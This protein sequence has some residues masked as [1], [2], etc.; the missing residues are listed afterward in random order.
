M[1]KLDAMEMMA[2]RMALRVELAWMKEV[3]K[4]SLAPEVKA[5]YQ[6]RHDRVEELLALFA[7][8][9]TVTIGT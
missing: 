6:N 8:G 9:H 4:G 5:D 3:V 1:R 2:I 7:V